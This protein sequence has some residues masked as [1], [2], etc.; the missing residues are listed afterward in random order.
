MYRR[1]IMY[2]ITIYIVSDFRLS[3]IKTYINTYIH[4]YID[5]IMTHTHC[6]DVFVHITKKQP[7]VYVPIPAPINR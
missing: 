1:A 4:T 7:S 3:S 5:I 6:L 2:S